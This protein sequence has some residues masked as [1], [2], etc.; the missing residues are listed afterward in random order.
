MAPQR[1][2]HIGFPKTG[3]TFLQ[4]YFEAHPNIYHNRQRFEHY[5]KAGVIDERLSPCD[6]VFSFDVLSEELLAIWPGDHSGDDFSKYNMNYDVKG[7]QKETAE[8]LK[9]LFPEAKVLIVV[10][11]YSSLISSLYSQYL[12]GGGFDSFKK[13]LGILEQSAL[14]L[15]NYDYAIRNYRELFGSDNVLVMPYEFL[16]DDPVQYLEHLEQFF[17]FQSYKFPSDRV[18]SSLNSHSVLAVRATNFLARTS[19]GLVSRKNRKQ[20]FLNYLEWLHNSKDKLNGFLKFGKAF[21]G[22]KVE[23][24]SEEF[25]QNSTLVRFNDSLK[26]YDSYYG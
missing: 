8:S 7:K 1:I 19:L 20:Q 6:E 13:T 9:R 21:P 2:I 17:G 24:R 5:V 12:F 4:K 15:F 16:L 18:H 22:Q 25:K 11:G 23:L 10:R 14:E 3:S 26:K